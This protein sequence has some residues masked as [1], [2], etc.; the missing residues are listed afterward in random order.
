MPKTKTEY[1]NMIRLRTSDKMLMLINNARRSQGA[2]D[3]FGMVPNQS[4]FLR[5]VIYYWVRKNAPEM[6]DMNGEI[7]EV[8]EHHQLK[9]K[10]EEQLG[11]AQKLYKKYF[12]NRKN[13][14]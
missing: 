10:Q 4:E 7:P 2:R 12:T 9:Q 14:E 11:E 6:L 3:G 13:E 1:Q 5:G 8:I